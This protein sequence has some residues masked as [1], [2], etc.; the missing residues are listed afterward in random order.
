MHII[1][2]SEIERSYFQK[3]ER[4]LVG[5]KTQAQQGFG[6]AFLRSSVENINVVGNQSS[7][8]QF[9]SDSYIFGIP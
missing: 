2:V 4:W 1:K 3:Y 7:R 5:Q 8:N 6:E 9:K